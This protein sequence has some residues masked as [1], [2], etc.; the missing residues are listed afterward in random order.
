MTGWRA[1]WTVARVWGVR[2]VVAALAGTAVLATL[3]Q[4]R[5]A[6]PMR[7]DVAEMIWPLAPCLLAF[8]VPSVAARAWTAEERVAPRSGWLHRLAFVGGVTGLAAAACAALAV[9]H[10]FSV[11]ARNTAFLVGLAL[12][13]A[14]LLPASARWV[15]PVM[16]PISMWLLGGRPVG[17]EPAGW[18]VLLHDGD[19]AVASWA[20][21]VSFAVGLGLYVARTRPIAE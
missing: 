20:A 14:V 17:L 21:A 6:V 8:T 10:P 11:L 1:A 18:A 16:V 13:G 4:G 7:R 12:T 5:I 15:P 2:Q 19:S 3:W 9:L